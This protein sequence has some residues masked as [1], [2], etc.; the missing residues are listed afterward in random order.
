MV[1]VTRSKKKAWLEIVHQIP[2]F[3]V[4]VNSMMMTQSFE[5]YLTSIMIICLLH[6]RSHRGGQTVLMNVHMT[7]HL[8]GEIASQDGLPVSQSA[9]VLFMAARYV[10]TDRTHHK[11][12][13]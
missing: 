10:H 5:H 4:N 13:Y 1:Y 11:A 2:V 9:I 7:K 3:S 8:S 12:L 6:E